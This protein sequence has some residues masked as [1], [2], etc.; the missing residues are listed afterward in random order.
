DFPDNWKDPVH[1]LI[2]TSPCPRD[3]RPLACRF[4]PLTPH[5][6]TDGTL[7][8]IPETARLPYRCPLIHKKIPLR[9]EFIEMVAAA[10][11]ELLKDPRIRRLVIEDSRERETKSKGNPPILWA[12]SPGS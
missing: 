8:L 4:F 5:L 1:F 11:R 3:K 12:G 2:C 7:A 9:E 10:W 6:L